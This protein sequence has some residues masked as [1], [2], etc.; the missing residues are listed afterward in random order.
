MWGGFTFEKSGKILGNQGK[1]M[2]FHGIEKWEPCLPG[3]SPFF[4]CIL[5][6]F[7]PSLFVH[8][9]LY[10]F[11]C[12]S[13]IFVLFSF[14]NLCCFPRTFCHNTPQYCAYSLVTLLFLSVNELV[15]TF[16]FYLWWFNL[17]I[18]SNVLIP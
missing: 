11:L 6:F 3:L 12:L 13:L 16:W 8:I 5:S 4:F 1:V 2:E 14:N 7:F 10:F 15:L 17:D 9:V 18:D